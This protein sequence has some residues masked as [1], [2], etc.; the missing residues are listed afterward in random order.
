MPAN[1]VGAAVKGKDSKYELVKSA[2]NRRVG[3]ALHFARPCVVAGP[4]QDGN[5]QQQP[6]PLVP[7]RRRRNS[8]SGISLSARFQKKRW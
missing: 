6:K 5:R 1:Q 3:K 2:E 8:S 4:K 7:Q